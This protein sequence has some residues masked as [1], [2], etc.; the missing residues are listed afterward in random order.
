MVAHMTNQLTQACRRMVED[1]VRGAFEGARG[2]PSHISETPFIGG[3][4]YPH[5]P[6]ASHAGLKR[7]VRA[8]LYARELHR[9]N[10]PRWAQ[11]LP[12]RARECFELKRL[13]A[14]PTTSSSSSVTSA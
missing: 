5:D 12:L 4:F 11:P 3:T 6:R 2:L 13:S 7:Q 1:Y 9:L 8:A 14:T 10:A